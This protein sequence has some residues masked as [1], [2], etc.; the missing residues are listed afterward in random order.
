M[1][2]EDY[3]I[4]DIAEIFHFDDVINNY[5]YKIIKVMR[6]VYLINA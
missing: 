4:D 5:F 2:A 1:D 3:D 6:N